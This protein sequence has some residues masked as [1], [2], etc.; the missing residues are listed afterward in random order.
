[1]TTW[2]CNRHSEWE[3]ALEPVVRG[4]GESLCLG[5]VSVCA[6]GEEGGAGRS[7]VGLNPDRVESDAISRQTT[8][9]LR[10]TF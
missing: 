6:Q 10:G 9:E 8:S 1:M 3:E 2:T 7:L 4:T 5:L